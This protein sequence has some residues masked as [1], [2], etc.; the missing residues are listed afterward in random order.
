MF[1]TQL[2]LKPKATPIVSATVISKRPHQEI[3]APPVP[4]K[5]GAAPKP[6]TQAQPKIQEPVDPRPRSE[7]VAETLSILQTEFPVLFPE[8]EA[9][10]RPFAVGIRG[11]LWIALKKKKAEGQFRSR[12]LISEAIA[13]YRKQ[14]PAYAAQLQIA[15]T[16][17]IGIDGKPQGS[18]TEAEAAYAQSVA[19]EQQNC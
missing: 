2:R 14:H 12:A 3:P 10:V 4:P 15:G 8:T 9:D 5:K 7:R 17:R 13:L 16:P 18:V 11:D 6:K 19:S 1:A